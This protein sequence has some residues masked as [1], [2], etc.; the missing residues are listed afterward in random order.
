MLANYVEDIHNGEQYFCLKVSLLLNGRIFCRSLH[1][2][3]IENIKYAGNTR[4]QTLKRNLTHKQ[5]YVSVLSEKTFST[6]QWLEC[7]YPHSN[8]RK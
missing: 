6:L 8:L 5:A 7:K 4:E 3:N 2:D 1:S